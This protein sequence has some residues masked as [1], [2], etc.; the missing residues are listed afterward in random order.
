MT[1]LFSARPRRG[2]QVRGIRW[3]EWILLSIGLAG[4]L[5]YLWAT[6]GGQA[7]QRYASRKFDRERETPKFGIAIPQLSQPT[8]APRPFPEATIGR[9]VIPRVGIQTMVQEGVS[10]SIL[11][12]A[13]GHLPGSSLPGEPG[14][15]AIAA[16]RDT[17]FRPLRDIRKLDVI[18]LETTQGSFDYEVESIEIVDPEDVSVVAQ[19][20]SPMLTLVTCYPFYYVG[21]APKR[22]IVHARE[23]SRPPESGQHAVSPAR[24]SARQMP[25]SAK[26]IL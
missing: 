3:I 23:L 7:M 10:A 5:V 16:H 9:L 14:N 8:V 18:T 1:T 20:S 15:V 24:F 13:A 6:L 26:E 12:H 4:I 25:P 21:S 22:F 11:R 17:F 2:A 19:T